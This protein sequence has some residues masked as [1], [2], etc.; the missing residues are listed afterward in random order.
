[1]W[2]YVEYVDIY[3]IFPLGAVVLSIL[4]TVKQKKTLRATYGKNKIGKRAFHLTFI[5]L[6]FNTS[7]AQNSCTIALQKSGR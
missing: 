1:M 7:Y 4:I 3:R 2:K 5:L 6:S